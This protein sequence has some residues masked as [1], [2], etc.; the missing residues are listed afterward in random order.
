M[1]TYSIKL[2]VEGNGSSIINTTEKASS[3][4]EARQKALDRYSRLYRGKEITIIS[5]NP[6]N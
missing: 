5:I 3:V 2:T 6:P 4:E 1:T